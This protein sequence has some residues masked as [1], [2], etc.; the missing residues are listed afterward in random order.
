MMEAC[1]IML[2]TLMEQLMKALTQ[3]ATASKITIDWRWFDLAKMSPTVL[4]MAIIGAIL[5][6]AVLVVS[7]E[8]LSSLAGS[9]A[10]ETLL[11]TSIKSDS[12]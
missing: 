10:V 11:V 5:L 9:V 6:G 12:I 3:Q 1:S 7:Q 8:V 4:A 2:K